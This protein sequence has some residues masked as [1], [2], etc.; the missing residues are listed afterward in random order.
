M[1]YSYTCIYTYI[2]IHMYT[3]NVNAYMDMLCEYAKTYMYIMHKQMQCIYHIRNAGM[4]QAQ[5]VPYRHSMYHI[6]KAC[7]I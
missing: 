4:I 7:T 1:Y 2:Y 5:H 6:G 3:H